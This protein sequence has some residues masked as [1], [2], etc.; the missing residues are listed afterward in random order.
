MNLQKCNSIFD[1]KDVVECE[2]PPPPENWW[3]VCLSVLIIVLVIVAWVYGCIYSKR[4][5]RE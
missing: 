4:L 3:S 1:G 5:E 2:D